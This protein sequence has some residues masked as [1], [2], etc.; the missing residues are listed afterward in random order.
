MFRTLVPP[1]TGTSTLNEPSGAAAAD[2]VVVVESW[3]VFVA[4]T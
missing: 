2:T 4:A 3:S 1:L